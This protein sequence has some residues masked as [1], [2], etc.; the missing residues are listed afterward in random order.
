MQIRAFVFE[1]SP[2]NT[3]L[4]YERKNKQYSGRSSKMTPPC[5]WPI[6]ECIE[7]LSIQKRRNEG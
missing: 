1:T 6:N 2:G 4:E 3:K 7:G 5:K